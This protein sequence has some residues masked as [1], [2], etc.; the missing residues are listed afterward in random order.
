MKQADWKRY[1]QYTE[2]LMSKHQVPGA[3]VGVAH[4]GK[5]IYSKGFGWANV[6]DQ[7]AIDE[8]TVF[9]IGSV[10]KSFTAVG[11]M[12]LH[13][14]GKL[15]V[16]DPVIKYLPEFKIGKDGAEK[17]MTI[18][19]FL[20]HTAGIPPLPSLTR[21]MVRSMKEDPEIMEGEQGAKLKDLPPIDTDLDLMEYIA[22]LEVRLF[23]FPGEHFSYSNDSYAL[24]GSIIGR[25][26]GLPYEEYVIKHILKP[27][28]MSR[29]LFDTKEIVQMDNVATLYSSKKV[30][31]KDNVYA[32]PRWIESPAMSAAGFLKSTTSDM[33]R[34]MEIFRTGGTCEGVRILSEKSV[35]QMCAPYAQPIPGQFYGYGMMVHG[36]YRGVSIVEHGGNIKGTSA[37]VSCVREKGLTV[38]SLTN[39]VSSP[40]SEIL[41]TAL[42]TAM[43]VPIRNPRYVYK[44]FSCP[45]DSLEHYTGKYV[46]GEGATLAV[47]A[48]G[49]GLEIELGED[50][51]LCRPIALDTF[52]MQR[53][54]QK[55]PV[56]FLRNTAGDVWA[57]A[58]GFRIIP[59]ALEE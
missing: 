59:K 8:N 6:D 34:Y 12:Q 53:K 28:G 44:P 48:K 16:D 42:N 15:S 54:G 7:A 49:A 3:A 35:G 29:S 31:G 10:T 26:S 22:G 32:S 51:F 1:E 40:S 46:S 24:L 56:R 36:N 17:H 58:T 25:V 21:A 41:L 14:Q 39:L 13:E 2:S 9:G 38:V 37:W 4:N 57:M 52:A 47:K 43:G 55:S 11:I 45:T 27:L 30:K 50:R 19:H 20:T 5:S 23:G 33:L 18:H